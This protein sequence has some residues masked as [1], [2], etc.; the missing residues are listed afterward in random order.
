MVTLN[1]TSSRQFIRFLGD[2]TEIYLF[3]SRLN[4][5]LATFTH[6]SQAIPLYMYDNEV[7]KPYRWWL[8]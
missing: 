6:T 1:E 3:I 8:G 7:S 5:T 2:I 4:F